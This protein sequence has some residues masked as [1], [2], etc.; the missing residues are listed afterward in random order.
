M[1][2]LPWEAM[3]QGAREQSRKDRAESLLDLRREASAQHGRLAEDQALL[4]SLGSTAISVWLLRARNL[5]T[6][7]FRSMLEHQLQQ[8]RGGTILVS[9]GA[10]V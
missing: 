2:V 3:L 1:Q 6:V 7:Y 8:A 5:Y 10:C 9:L 4:G